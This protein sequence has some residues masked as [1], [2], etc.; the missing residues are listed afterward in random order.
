MNEPFVFRKMLYLVEATGMRARTLDQ[1][2]R[3]VTVVDPLS[4]GFHMHREYLEFRF[5]DPEWPND[6]SY[7]SAK[8]LGDQVL[9]EKLAAL[10]VFNYRTLEGLQRHLARML[11][12]HMESVPESTHLVAPHGRDFIFSMARSIVMDV[13]R[14]TR[15]LEEFANALMEVEGSSIYFHIFE[16]RFYGGE[17]HAIDFALWV[18]QSLGMPELGERMAAFDPYVFSLEGAR[19]A[20]VRMVTEEARAK[21]GE[22]SAR[23]QPPL[24]GRPE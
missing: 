22:A 1:M 5:V 17:G 24:P 3:V 4:I 21:R 11:A 16:T 15:T 7:W 18:T 13:G 19:K 12:E 10:R 9:A 2:L 14:Q 8:V 20:M 6:F 23:P